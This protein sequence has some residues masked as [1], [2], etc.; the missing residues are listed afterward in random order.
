M[1]IGSAG[2]GP[3]A[4]WLM[5]MSAVTGVRLNEMTV[6]GIT[7]RTHDSGGGASHGGFADTSCAIRA[8]R[9]GFIDGR[10]VHMGWHVQM[11][12]GLVG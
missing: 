6:E 11:L 3:I 2:R 4:T 1:A 8:V 10:P 12:A 5:I 7:Q 9:V